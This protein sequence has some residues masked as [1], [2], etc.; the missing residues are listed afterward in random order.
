MA[1]IS[2]Q[3]TSQTLDRIRVRCAVVKAAPFQILLEWQ[4]EKVI[5]IDFV[6]LV[7]MVFLAEISIL[8]RMY[9]RISFSVQLWSIQILSSK[10]THSISIVP[11]GLL[12]TSY[13]TLETPAISFTTL[14]LTRFRNSPSNGNQSAV[15]KS[16]VSTARN[17]MT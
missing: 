13:T 12:V 3:A 17:A 9:I 1:N 2:H 6:V 5:Q 16:V 11:G 7:S 10:H 15:M 14:R 4:V 8:D